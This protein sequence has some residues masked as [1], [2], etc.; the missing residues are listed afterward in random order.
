MTLS[1]DEMRS[2]YRNK[3]IQFT[4]EGKSNNLEA[5]KKSGFE[6]SA[7]DELIKTYNQKE[8]EL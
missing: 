4:Q 5:L 8:Y 3:L 6:I 7:R 2:V 1:M